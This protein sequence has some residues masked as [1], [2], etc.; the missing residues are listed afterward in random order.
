MNPPTTY[1]SS[2]LAADLT[3]ELCVQTRLTLL[4]GV[5]SLLHLDPLGAPEVLVELTEGVFYVLQ[6][7]SLVQKGRE[8]Q[9]ESGEA[10]AGTCW[11]A[12]ISEEP[13]MSELSL[14]GGQR[15]VVWFLAESAGVPATFLFTADQDLVILVVRDGDVGSEETGHQVLQ[16][17]S[18]HLLHLTPL[19]K[20]RENI[21]LETARSSETNNIPRNKC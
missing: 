21:R 2:P 10:G 13:G 5:P 11:R 14:G 16:L 1:I 18:S 7:E 19:Q 15:N 20:L 3:V 6:R 4:T 12:E 8:L 17:G 9:T